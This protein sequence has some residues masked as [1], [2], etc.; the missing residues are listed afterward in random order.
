MLLC[1]TLILLYEFQFQVVERM[2]HHYWVNE[3]IH[4][5]CSVW[6]L[7]SIIVGI[8]SALSIV[9]TVARKRAGQAINPIAEIQ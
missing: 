4:I 5:C 7:Q 1:A 8:T 2:S 9:T 3:K 6:T